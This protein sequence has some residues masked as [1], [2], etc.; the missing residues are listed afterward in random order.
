MSIQYLL[1]KFG[2]DTAENESLNV[3]QTL[4]KR[5]KKVRTNIGGSREPDRQAHRAAVPLLQ[6]RVR[7]RLSAL[8]QIRGAS[9]RP[10]RQ[11]RRVSARGRCRELFEKNE[12]NHLYTLRRSFSS[13][14]K[15]MFA[16]KYSFFSIFRNL[17]DLHTF[18]PLRI[19]NFSKSSSNIFAF[20]FEFL[21]I[22]RIFQR[23]ASILHRFS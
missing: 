22:I 9:V 3:C 7:V 15:P 19:Q 23:I 5:Q 21:Q 18:A 2:V 11:R 13:V 14:S 10:R 17:Q 20:S 16:I 4:A 12:L 1:A 6:R 8:G